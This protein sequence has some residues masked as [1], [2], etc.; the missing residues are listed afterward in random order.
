MRNFMFF[1]KRMLPKKLLILLLCISMILC[2]SCQSP[3]SSKQ[4]EP[5]TA[6]SHSDNQQTNQDFDAFVKE[7]FCNT[8]TSS[9]IYLHTF[10]EHPENYGIT[11]YD[12][13]YGNIDLENLD[14]MSNLS[15]SL[16][17]LLCYDRDSLTASQKITYDELKWYL[18]T[19]L[20]YSDLALLEHIFSPVIGVNVQLPITL[21]QYAFKEEKDVDEYLKLLEDTDRYFSQ[22]MEYE[23]LKSER[24]YFMESANAEKIIKQ[25][26]EFVNDCS[27]GF[28]ITSFKERLDTLHINDENKINE[29]IEKNKKAVNEHVKKAYQIVV[30]GFNEIKNTG[31]CTGGLCNYPNGDKYYQYLLES[32]MGWGKSVDEYDDFINKYI[33]Y[34]S[35]ILSKLMTDDIT[36]AYQL[37]NLSFGNKTPENMLSDLKN[38]IAN[39]FPEPVNV[40]YSIKY[41]AE[42]LQ[43]YASPAMYFFPQIDDLNDNSIYINPGTNDASDLY[44]T[45]AHEGYPGHLYQTT[46]F[47]NTKPDLIRHLISLGGYTEGWGTYCEA[48][49]YMYAETDN[50]SLKTL[51]QANFSLTMLMYGKIDIG[52]N[53]YGWTENDVF[54]FIETFGVSSR[55]IAQDMYSSIVAEPGNYAKYVLGYIGFLELKEEA[56]KLLKDSFNL[57]EFHQYILDMGP[58]PFKMLFDNL[59]TLTVKTTASAK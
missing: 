22:L 42:S 15:D 39:D 9:T 38:K 29:Y 55:S 11:E 33:A 32:D 6:I 45:M 7:L 35:N 53:H 41:I 49:S 24:G 51:A 59:N 20:E 5:T 25:C 30:D 3:F 19:E 31:K 13:T 18:E 4:E 26:Q 21:A 40:G 58:V 23:K 10:L 48:A 37:E 47:V 52:I 28:L 2:S 54:N 56:K 46:Y 44:T 1:T 16:S 57:K 17:Q 34:F 43:P 50:T 36:L 27:D 8:V 14:D 12:V